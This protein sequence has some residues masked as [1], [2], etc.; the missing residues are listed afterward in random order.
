M[1]EDRFAYL[2]DKVANFRIF[3]LNHNPDD[4]VLEQLKAYE[5]DTVIATIATVV[6]PMIALRGIPSV[7]LELFSHL[8]PPKGQDRIDVIHKIERY[9]HCFQEGMMEGLSE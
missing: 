9:L 5:P 3:I 4:I 8:R 2:K 1:P 7:A 6:L